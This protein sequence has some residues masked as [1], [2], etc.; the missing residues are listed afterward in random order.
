MLSKEEIRA[1]C[2]QLLQVNSIP[3]AALGFSGDEVGPLLVAAADSNLPRQLKSQLM[4]LSPIGELNEKV[5]QCVHL[6]G[7]E[8]Q[9]SAQTTQ[10][11]TP[12][13]R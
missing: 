4:F 6:G 1:R 2:E 8:D 5:L 11:S 9:V 10:H 13:R 12:R 7:H 3:A